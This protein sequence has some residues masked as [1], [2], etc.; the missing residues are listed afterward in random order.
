MFLLA[1]GDFYHRRIVEAMPRLRDKKQ[2]L[3]IIRDVERQ[4]SRYLGAIFLINV[5]LGRR[6]RASRMWLLGMP[7]GRSSGACWRSC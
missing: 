6:G 3:T 4:I 7:H 2:A 1:A 5:G